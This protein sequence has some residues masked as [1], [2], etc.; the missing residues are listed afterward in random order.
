MSRDDGVA[1]LA[2][3][4]P[5]ALRAAI[6]VLLAGML[7]AA[8]ALLSE[9]HDAGEARIRAALLVAYELSVCK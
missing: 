7:I 5:Q 4:V 8:H 3:G 2:I 9:I 6:L 1:L